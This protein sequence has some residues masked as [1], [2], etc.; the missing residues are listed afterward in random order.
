M[1]REE[2]VYKIILDIAKNDKR[3]RAVELNG[4]RSNKNAIKDNY[5]DFDIACH[6]TDLTYYKNNRKFIENFMSNFGELVIMQSS[7]DQ[8]DYDINN[9]DEYIYMMQFEDG[10]RIDLSFS[11]IKSSI[12]EDRESL[13][14]ILLDK[15]NLFDNDHISDEQDFYPKKPTN[16]KFHF[17]TNEFWWLVIYVAK[18]IARKEV[19][20]TKVMFECYL[21]DELFK[22]INW[23]IGMT[24]G[25]KI[26]SGKLGKNY[27]ALL[28]EKTYKLYLATFCGIDFKNMTKCLFNICELYEKLSVDVANKNHLDYPLN[29]AKNVKQYILNMKNLGKI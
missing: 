2:Q 28:D 5:Q 9:N 12:N 26:S 4:S 20:F 6:V 1:K 13:S 25:Y 11:V 10:I 19:T 21:R 17:S 15:D 23:Y 16:E 3:I 8:S 29:E 14:V 27:K 22:M 18:G 24:N 7:L